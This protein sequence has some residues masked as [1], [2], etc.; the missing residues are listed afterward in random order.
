ME[1]KKVNVGIVAGSAG[2]WGGASRV[3]Y[4]NLRLLDLDRIRPVV[5]LPKEGPIIADLKARNI[6]YLIWGGL[7]ELGDFGAALKAMWRMFR[8]IRNQEVDVIHVNQADSWRPVELLVA[9]YLGIPVVTHLHTADNNPSPYVKQSSAILAVSEFVARQSSSELGPKYVVH[10]PVDLGRFDTAKD[11]RGEWA[12]S[13]D[14][15][16]ISFVGQIREI[17]GVGDFIAMA[18]RIDL[19]NARFLI[20][21]ECRDPKKFEGAYSEDDLVRAFAG[22]ERFRYLGYLEQVEDLYR[23]SDIIVMPSRWQEPLGLIGIETGAC[24]KPVVAT[25]SGGIPEVVL[26]GE[27]GLLVEIGD[28][29]GLARGVRMLMDDRNR[30]E[31]MGE[32]ARRRVEEKF[33]TAPVRELEA[34]YEELAGR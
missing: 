30:R 27:T 33:T 20:A 25:R 32:A 34:V 29:E 22:D 1:K 26:D 12:S 15:I 3:L 7:T 21:G 19:P 9:K 18:H 28:V 23:S 14:D 17:K 8:F 31:R 16:L 4:T 11:M 10:N 2:D 24:G 5:M 6:E 13:K